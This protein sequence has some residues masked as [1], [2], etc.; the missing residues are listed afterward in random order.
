MLTGTMCHSLLSV[1]LEESSPVYTIPPVND[2]S[3]FA[4]LPPTK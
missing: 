3:G 1:E 4:P 2:E